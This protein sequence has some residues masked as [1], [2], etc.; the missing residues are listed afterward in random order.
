MPS[1]Q[2][3]LGARPARFRRQRLLIVG[4]GDVGAARGAACWRRA[5]AC[6][7][8]RLRRAGACPARAPG[9]TPLAGN[10][11]AP[12]T[13]PA[14]RVRRACCTWRRRRQAGSRPA[15]WLDPRTRALTQLRRRSPAHNAG[16][17]LPGGVYGDCAGAWVNETA[18]PEASTPR[19]Q[20]RVDAEALVRH[21]GRVP[22]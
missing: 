10:L 5:C 18:G 15:W 17:W 4:C 2:S 20:R 19:A 8:S 1:N 13:S 22:A 12:A 11:D 16:V 7:R 6:W 14:G 9:V 21:L 3:P